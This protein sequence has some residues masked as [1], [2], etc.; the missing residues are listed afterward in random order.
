MKVPLYFFDLITDIAL[1]RDTTGTDLRDDAEAS[2]HAKSVALELMRGREAKTQTWHLVVYDAARRRCLELPFGD[3]DTM[4][5]STTAARVSAS[6]AFEVYGDTP[7]T[8]GSVEA[9]RA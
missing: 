7:G 5:P 1:V 3:A 4:Y 2:E 6:N 9:G 8:A